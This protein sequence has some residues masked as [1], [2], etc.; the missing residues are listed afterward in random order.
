MMLSNT[1]IV[2]IILLYYV[3]REYDNHGNEKM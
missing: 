3:V 1:I 2:Q